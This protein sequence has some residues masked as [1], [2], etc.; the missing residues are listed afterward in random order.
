MA[1]KLVSFGTE[2]TIFGG[3]ASARPAPVSRPAVLE[4]S[5]VLVM[6]G[7]RKAGPKDGPQALAWMDLQVGKG[8][9]VTLL[10]PAGAGKS[11]AIDLVAGFLKPDAGR[12]LLGGEL[13]DRVPPHRRN[14][15][16]VSA[17]PDLFPD[18]TVLG[19]AAFPLEARGVPRAEREERATAMLERW[20]IPSA[21]G[22]SRPGALPLAQQLRVAFAR[23]LVHAPALLLLDDPLRALEGEE[24]VAL[25]A[26]LGRLRRE[27]DLTTLH[28]TRDAGIALVLSDRIAALEEGKLRQIG[29]PH[30]LYEAPADPVVAALTGPCN[31][32]PGTVLS[33][34]DEACHVRL[35]CGLEV[36]GRP[37]IAA[38]G[39]PV[40]GGRCTLVI[41]P[42]QVAVAP[43]SATEM[44]EDAVPA[45]LVEASFVGDHLRLRLAIGQGGELIAHR[46]PGLPLPALGGEAS[47]AW[48]LSAARIHVG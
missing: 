7:I 36:L 26:D 27:L 8:D 38:E 25:A 43:L 41:R 19:N 10:G 21:L 23:A 35:D 12:L 17:A 13:Q 22:R 20:G 48:N 29:T 40:P 24:R 45:R 3:D 6:E 11:V 47:V 30:D 46:P 33:V 18:M 14:I 31:R 1:R 16:L 9:F 5:A 32:L 39:S 34:K 28:A 2:G 15:G 42:G 4:V 37:V 44:G